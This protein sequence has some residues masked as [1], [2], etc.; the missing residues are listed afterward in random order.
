MAEQMNSTPAQETNAN[1]AENGAS[2]EARMFT[3]EELNNIISER[4][5]RERAKMEPSP[6]EQREQE[7]TARENRLSCREYMEEKGYPMGLM[8]ILDTSNLQKFQETIEALDKVIKLPSKDYKPPVFS[9]PA[10][11]GTGSPGNFVRNRGTYGDSIADA[12]RP[13]QR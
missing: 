9:V 5:A 13:P 4:L 10:P 2:N 7:L 12:F 3:Q 1:P 11:G 6:M 8:D